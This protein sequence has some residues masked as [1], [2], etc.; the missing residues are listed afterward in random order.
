MINTKFRIRDSPRGLKGMGV[1][2][3]QGN[4]SGISNRRLKHGRNSVF[5]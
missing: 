2:G 3:A 4:F 5:L 1:H